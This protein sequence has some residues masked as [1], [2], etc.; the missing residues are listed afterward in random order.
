MTL[1]GYAR[2]STADQSTD[3]QLDALDAAGCERVFTDY[4]SGKLARRPQLDALLDY[5][6]PRDVIVITKLDRLGRSLRDLLA[7]VANLDERDVDLKVLDQTIDTTGPAGK[8]T[9][10]ILGAVAEFERDLISERTRDGLA[11]ARARGRKGGRRPVLSPAKITHARK[12]RDGGEHTMTE[13]ADLVGCSRATLYRVLDAE[14]PA[15]G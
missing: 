2:V 12:L 1:I 15:T 9:F 4:A 7:L 11:A 3:G 10:A 14:A 13:I 8:L 5:A 6:R